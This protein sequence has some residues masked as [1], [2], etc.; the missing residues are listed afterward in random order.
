MAAVISIT[1]CFKHTSYTGAKELRNPEG[2]DHSYNYKDTTDANYVLFKEKLRSFSSKL[3]ESYAKR[4]FDKENNIVISPLSAEMCLGLAVCASDGETRQ[5]LLN[6]FGL[7]YNTFNKYYKLYFNELSLERKNSAKQLTSM[8]LLANSIWID[9]EVSLKDSGLDSLKN[10][11]YSYSY[12]VDFDKKNKQANQ[13][14]REFVKD[15]TKGLINQD[16]NISPDTLFMLMNTLYLKD[17]WNDEGSNMSYASGDYKFT[18]Y[19]GSVS[20]KSLLNGYYNSGK[21]IS[22]T[23]YSSFYTK[24]LSG[25]KVFFVKPNAGKDIKDVFTKDT[26]DYVINSDSYTYIDVEKKE[27][28]FTNCIFPEYSAKSDIDL[29]SIFKE[30]FNVQTLFDG[31]CNFSNLSKDSVYCSDFKQVSKLEVNKKG[32]EGAAVTYMAYAGSAGPGELTNVYDTFVVDRSFGFVLTNNSSDII[33][34]GI[35]TN[36]D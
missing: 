19:N 3:S 25:F 24:T 26:I 29:V 1:G 9:D 12:N 8:L 33:F 35:V 15:K 36:I 22:N 11:Y 20:S 2:M 30:D 27:A 6:V 16:L 34:S 5:E 10:N 31:R 4:E 18:N 13:A 7:D 14:I 21:I 17:I 32:I 28:Y 23:N